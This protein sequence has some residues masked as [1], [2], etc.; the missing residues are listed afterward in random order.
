M[1]LSHFELIYITR[2]QKT[3]HINMKR[4]KNTVPSATKENKSTKSIFARR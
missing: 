2:N 1:P 3:Y 4:Q